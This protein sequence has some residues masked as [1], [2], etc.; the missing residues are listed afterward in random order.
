MRADCVNG[1]QFQLQL[2]KTTGRIC[3]MRKWEKGRLNSGMS[4]K[5]REKV[6]VRVGYGKQ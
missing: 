1:I 3:A 2:M 5:E 4:G 6:K